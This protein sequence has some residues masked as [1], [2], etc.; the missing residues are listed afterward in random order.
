MTKEE[1]QQIAELLNARNE[2][3]TAYTAAK[4]LQRAHDYVFEEA[5]GAVAACVQVKKVQWYQS[6]ICHLSV[7]VKYEG[8][9][10]GK[11]LIQLAEEKAL[12]EGARIVQCTIR[13]GNVRSEAAFRRSG[14]R[15]ASNFYNPGTERY[16]NVWQK[17]LSGR[18]PA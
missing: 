5:D 2:L 11:R 4:V 1:A 13:I 3:Q 16:V 18:P 6:E 8:Q 9:G 7:G 17:V 14:Y 15:V 10:R 12:K